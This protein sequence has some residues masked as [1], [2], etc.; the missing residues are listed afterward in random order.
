LKVKSQSRTLVLQ[1][2]DGEYIHIDA[3]A[4]KSVL[5]FSLQYSPVAGTV[6][7]ITCFGLFVRP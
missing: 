6:K 7:L 2:C 1:V 5:Y 4:S 3:G